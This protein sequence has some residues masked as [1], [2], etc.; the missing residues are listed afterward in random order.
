MVIV[1]VSGDGGGGGMDA[2]VVSDFG[3]ESTKKI[4][5]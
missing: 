1:S 2:I 3:C 5:H 4:N